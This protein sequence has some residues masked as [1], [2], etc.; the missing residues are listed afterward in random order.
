MTTGKC[1][2][3]PQMLIQLSRWV[4][5]TSCYCISSGSK[6]RVIFCVFPE[7]FKAISFVVAAGVGGCV[8]FFYVPALIFSE[9]QGQVGASSIKASLKGPE[10][11]VEA[12]IGAEK[13]QTTYHFILWSLCS[14]TELC[15]PDLQD[16]LRINRN[17]WESRK[18]IIRSSAITA[19]K[20]FH[21]IPKP[22]DKLYNANVIPPLPPPAPSYVDNYKNLPVFQ[23]MDGEM[24]N[25]GQKH[26]PV[27][28]LHFPAPSASTF[29]SL[30][31][32]EAKRPNNSM[33]WQRKPQ[34]SLHQGILVGNISSCKKW[35]G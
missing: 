29:Q 13:I 30:I 4:L 35:M 12:G 14:Q 16:G 1:H 25:F 32:L 34:H 21:L 6:N 9:F 5:H 20:S 11:H 23:R 19:R 22:W 15:K 7:G 8:S 3:S 18:C 24:M 17:K 10:E 2:V 31:C 26:F 33:I 27:G 28:Q